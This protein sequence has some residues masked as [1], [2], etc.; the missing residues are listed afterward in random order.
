MK[1]VLS[2]ILASIFLILSLLHFYWVF[3][4][5]WGLDGAMPKMMQAKVMTEKTRT[6][7]IISTLVVAIGLLGFMMISLYNSSL[8]EA[9]FSHTWLWWIT[10]GMAAIFLLRAIGDFKYV[11]IFK[12]EKEGLFARRDSRIYVPLCLFLFALLFTITHFFM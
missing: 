2:L 10:I 1:D 9:P 8:I 6:G 4:G 3:G 12:K 7:F 11:G 5:K